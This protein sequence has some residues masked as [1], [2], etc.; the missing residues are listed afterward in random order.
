MA[1]GF[2]GRWARR[3]NDASLGRP[4][5]DPV[6]EPRL[7]ETPAPAVKTSPVATAPDTPASVE[8][9]KEKT[10]PPSMEDVKSL[11]QKSDYSSFVGE[12]VDPGVRN[13]A[14]KKL[15]SDPHFNEIDWMDVY[16][17]DYSKLEPMPLAMARKMVS[18]KFL[19]LFDEEQD[20]KPVAPVR[21]NAPLPVAD[22]AASET[23]R[24]E[25]ADKPTDE[26]TQDTDTNKT[27][28]HD[29]TDLRLQQDHAAGPGGT[30]RGTE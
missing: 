12:G 4:L 3:K 22:S 13:A 6:P 14:M 28:H 26:P 21:D 11:T 23:A 30:G 1:D 29:H 5:E 20:K 10:P 2:L 7:S 8:Q 17:D 24:I 9:T 25:T 18:A 15:F 19:D 27:E 16:M